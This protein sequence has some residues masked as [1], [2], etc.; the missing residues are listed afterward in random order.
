MMNVQVYIKGVDGA[1]EQIELFKDESV[2]LTQSIQNIKDISKIFT[3]F[4]KTFNVP[5]SKINNRILKHFYSADVSS[6]NLGIKLECKLYLNH[7]FFRKGKIQLE[8]ATMKYNKAHT[9]KLTFFGDTIKLPDLIGDDTLQS[10]TYLSYID[11]IYNPTTVK[12]YLQDGLDITANGE[13]FTD[14]IVI[15]LISHTKRLFYDSSADVSDTGNLHYGGSQNKGVLYN[16]LK[17]AIRLHYIIRAIEDKYKINFDSQFFNPTNNVYYDLYMWMHVNKGK[18]L[19]NTADISQ[20]PRIPVR[21]F[22]NVS[23]TQWRKDDRAENGNYVGNDYWQFR[24]AQEVDRR[25]TYDIN[26]NTQN[27]NYNVFVY[28]NGAL[29]NNTALYNVSGNQ[30]LTA[31]TGGITGTGGASANLNNFNGRFQIFI[32]STEDADFQFNVSLAE[33]QYTLSSQAGEESTGEWLNIDI[34]TFQG[35]ATSSD[36]VVFNGATQIPDINVMDF[37]TGLFKMFNLTAYID[38]ND[39]INV[40]PLDTFYANS[41]NT[42]NI[43]E[44]LDTTGSDVSKTTPYKSLKFQYEGLDTFFAKHHKAFFG[45]DWGTEMYDN[46]SRLEGETYEVSIPFEHHKFERLIDAGNNQPTDVQWG[47]SVDDDLNSYVGMPLIF[48]PHKI[49]SGTAISFQE[50]QATKESIT[51]YYVPLNHRLPTTDSQTLHFSL[52][53]SEYA[54]GVDQ[55]PFTKSLYGEYYDTYV[56]DTFNA[57]RRLYNFKAYLPLRILLNL[58]LADR[59]VIYGTLYK[60]NTLKT[61]FATGLSTLEL[62]NDV[63]QFKLTVN[64]EELADDVSQPYLTVDSVQVTVDNVPT[65]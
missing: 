36:D 27:T 50:S 59:V 25:W 46:E 65:V 30:R 21:D 23:N 35:Y 49:T 9:Y 40:T 60:I 2:T 45:T 14:A 26:I 52:E 13:T 54:I 39:I 24:E 32:Q 31:Y 48:Y 29:H 58:T 43:T 61:N 6:Y 3:D 8:G 22:Q 12:A 62:I 47:W 42:W 55:I 64:Q 11:F 10:L 33:S 56:R 44:Y 28:M 7:Q 53:P 51:N 17:P 19:V 15:P 20:A 16:D 18:L 34:T 63:S 4:T 57:R 1:F 5:A 41:K 37:L 38:D